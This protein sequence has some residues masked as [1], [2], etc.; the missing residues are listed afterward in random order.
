M[1]RKIIFAVVVLALGAGYAIATI[2]SSLNTITV[3]GTGAQTAFSF[4]FVGVAASDIAVIYTDSLG[5]STTLAQGLGVTQY[6]VSLNAAVPP[7]LWG[8]G[9]TITY[10]PS[11]TPIASNTT[12]TIT[13]TLP[14]LQLTSLQNQASWGQLAQA[15]EMAIDQLEMQIQQISNGF[16]LAL[17]APVNDPAGLNYTLP[18]AAQRAGQAL[19]FDSAGNV[20]ACATLP[21]GTV[22]SVMA[23]VV[24]A[25]SLAA[26]RTA[27]GLGSAATGGINYGLQQ[28][29]SGTGLIDVNSA[30]VQD[31]VNQTVTAAFQQ[32]QRT[33]SG[34]ITY[35][36]PRANTTWAGFGFW[37][38]A[39]SGTCTIAPNAADNFQGVAGGT[40]IAVNPGSWVY[41]TTSAAS[42]GVWWVDYHGAASANLVAGV[43]SSAL[44]LTLY[45]GPLLFRDTTLASG[46]PVWS[47]PANGISITI[48]S[49]ATLG[50]ASSN[51]P[52][53]IW[54]FAAYNS[55]TPILGVAVCSISTAIYPCT[56]WEAQQKTGTGISTGS[57][58]A[59]TLYTSSTTSND[60]VIIIGYAD[61]SSGL[62]TAGTWASAPTTLQSCLPPRQ[63]NRP[64]TIVQ[65][66]TNPTTTAGTTTSSTFASLT[67]GQSL[68]I[69][70]SSTPNIVRI[71]AQGTISGSTAG[72]LGLQ[73]QRTST[74]IGNPTLFVIAT[75]AGGS[76]APSF[77]IVYDRPGTVSSTTYSFQGKASS[78]TLSYPLANSGAMMELQE[79]MGALP[80]PAN[81][82]GLFSLSKVG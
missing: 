75:G 12:L 78:G 77:L 49:T 73:V 55:G 81:D 2:S 34:P 13:R 54:I 4:P 70:P 51:V 8:A 66:V 15:T 39:V 30:P 35:T 3:A 26:G 18:T 11:G 79:I 38:Y 42:S 48:P 41:I 43:A 10:N 46:D 22:S 76:A 6:Q 27:L 1:I 33:C 32:T 19:C 7:S 21:A 64:G 62:A 68:S 47:L 52:F 53:R 74:L 71:V 56:S 40:A 45:S 31:S 25:A 44:T 58:A 63:C 72:T 37:V 20:G 17:K 69:A 65:T 9:G 50:T 60:S 80:E 28:G 57:T 82:N 23:P 61:Y 36:L 14:Y 16:A 67:N 59:G 24:N 5:N 29:V